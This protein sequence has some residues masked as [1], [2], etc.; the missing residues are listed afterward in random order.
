[1]LVLLIEDSETCALL[2]KHHLAANLANVEII[3]AENLA[4]VHALLERKP[5]AIVADLGLPDSDSAHATIDCLTSI[6][7][8]IPTIILTGNDCPETALRSIC[9]G[10][11]AYFNKSDYSGIASMLKKV[12]G[13]P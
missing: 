4:Q 13:V 7:S 5:D 3:H 10:A 2:L 1:M 11:K 12:T 9:A 6:M 8:T